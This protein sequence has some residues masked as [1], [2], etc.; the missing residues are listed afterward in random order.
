MFSRIPNLRIFLV[1]VTQIN[2]VWRN[3]LH[4]TANLNYDLMCKKAKHCC[5][6]S[7]NCFAQFS[8]SKAK[9]DFK[10][11]SSLAELVQKFKFLQNSNMGKWF[12]ETELRGSCL[13][14]FLFFFLIQVLQSVF[15]FVK[16]NSYRYIIWSQ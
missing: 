11:L 9:H 6:L 16:I 2:F 1:K 8:W 12:H 13:D 4:H 14:R 15:F 3:Q 5:V 10:K 7:T